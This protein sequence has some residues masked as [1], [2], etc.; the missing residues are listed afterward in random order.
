MIKVVEATIGTLLA[1]IITAILTYTD[2]ISD[3]AVLLIWY[4]QQDR[5]YFANA[6]LATISLA[7]TLQLLLTVYQNHKKPLKEQSVEILLL[8]F[9][10]APAVN[11]FRAYSGKKQSSS[12]MVS[13]QIMHVGLKC[14]EIGFEAVIGLL[15]QMLA[16]L[17]SPDTA[18]TTQLVSVVVSV[19]TIAFGVA[20][21]FHDKDVQPESRILNPT[22]HGTLPSHAPRRWAAMGALLVFSMCHVFGKCL[23]LTL[24]WTTYGGYGAGGFWLCDFLLFCLIKISQG[25]FIYWLPAESTPA[26]MNGMLRRTMKRLRPSQSASPPATCDASTAKMQ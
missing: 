13:H 5:Q 18:T 9:M 21:M 7:M 1:V 2:V 16:I 3:T 19:L 4:S 23:G 17:S 11:A 25:D 24:L 12:D 20:T 22:F 10:L 15:I 8:L 6:L 26:T 14:T